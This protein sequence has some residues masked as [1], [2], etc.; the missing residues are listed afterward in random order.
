MCC[1]IGIIFL[2]IHEFVTSTTIYE[3]HCQRMSDECKTFW[4]VALNIAGIGTIYGG[5]C[6]MVIIIHKKQQSHG[7]S[8]NYAIE[9]KKLKY[10]L[11]TCRPEE[12]K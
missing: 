1:N 9:A 6:F 12:Y 4:G 2:H 10:Y 11:K 7:S 3:S 5:E 8:S